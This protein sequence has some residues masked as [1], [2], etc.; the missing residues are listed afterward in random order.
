MDFLR[1]L[2]SKVFFKHLA[3]AIAIGLIILLG[4]L[5]WL[6]IYTHHG[7][8]ISVPNLT[9]LNEEEVSDVVSSRKL[10]YVVVDSI[11]AADMP[12]GTVVKQNPKPNSKVKVRRKIFVTMNAVSPEKV[13][14]PDLVALSDR[15]AILALENSGLTLGNISYKP[16]FAVN[17]VL[18]QMLNGSVIPA[19]SMV[20]KGTQIDLVLGM[21]LSREKVPV[22]DLFGLTLLE[23]KT[24]LSKAFLNFGLATYDESILTA[25]DSAAAFVIRQNPEF[26]GYSRINKGSDVFLWITADSSL[27]PAPDSLQV[28]SL[29]VETAYD[30]ID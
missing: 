9:G 17:S 5:V 11:Y 10:N 2:I 23:A 6:K 7:Q 22:P 26:D 21:G 16:D 29:E 14:M 24:E 1:F 19:G 8:Q 30:P 13:Y 3:L 12:R 4:T 25:E 18:Q 15:Q 27:L 20:E 28:D